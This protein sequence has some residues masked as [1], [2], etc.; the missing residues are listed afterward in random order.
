MTTEQ[1]NDVT[2][3]TPSTVDEAMGEVLGELSNSATLAQKQGEHTY[4]EVDPDEFLAELVSLTAQ[5]KTLK[6]QSEVRIKN[7]MSEIKDHWFKYGKGFEDRAQSDIRNNTDGSKYVDYAY[8]RASLR[9][10]PSNPSVVIDDPETAEANA[11]LLIG[12]EAVKV[13][14]NRKVLLDK[15]KETGEELPGTHVEL[16]EER[17]EFYPKRPTQEIEDE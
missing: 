4:P 10:I 5:L 2:E 7:K 14:L 1:T 17:E 12:P 15:F 6:E 16:S 9:K 8:G 13:T 3:P 11:R